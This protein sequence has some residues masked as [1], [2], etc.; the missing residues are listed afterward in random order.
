MRNNN[1]TA[2]KKFS[3]LL[4]LMQN[5]KHSKT[6]PLIEGE[7]AKHDSQQ[8]SDLFNTFFSSKSQVANPDDDPPNLDRK[9]G[10]PDLDN[11]NT[12]PLEL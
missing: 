12:S 3:I 8:K 10:I 9:P 6:P 11:I 4:K 7:Q 1:I 5:N 2:K